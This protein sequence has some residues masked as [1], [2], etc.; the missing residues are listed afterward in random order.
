M[1]DIK[2][3]GVLYESKLYEAPVFPSVDSC[4]GNTKNESS[5]TKL[6][7][8]KTINYDPSLWVKE[9]HRS[10]SFVRVFST[11]DTELMLKSCCMEMFLFSARQTESTGGLCKSRWCVIG[12]SLFF[13]HNHVMRVW[14]S[15]FPETEC[16]IWNRN[17]GDFS[18][19]LLTEVNEKY[20]LIE[21]FI[22]GMN[23]DDKIQK[24]K[25]GE[26][27]NVFVVKEIPREM[28]CT[29]NCAIDRGSRYP[30]H[31]KG[32][33]FKHCVI[34]GKTPSDVWIPHRDKARI[35]YDGYCEE[36]TKTELKKPPLGLS[37]K[38]V[39]N[40]IRIQEILGAIGRYSEN[41]MVVPSEW[42]QE[43]SDRLKQNGILGGEGK[44]P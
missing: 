33:Q 25:R 1:K 31:E 16:T 11:H 44:K 24:L 10:D 30:V 40:D 42:L 21:F 27:S 7:N 20:I 13:L 38:Y 5:G 19:S 32:K 22:C 3:D 17:E 9:F 34:V 6:E 12:E 18:Y 39:Y 35:F 28:R 15:L 14:N 26:F 43:L 41:G 2:S 8:V 29:V 36:Q 4:N 23:N 37:P